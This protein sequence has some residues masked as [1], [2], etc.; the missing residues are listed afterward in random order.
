MKYQVEV[1]GSLMVSKVVLV[2]T[3]ISASDRSISTRQSWVKI[4][5]AWVCYGIYTWTLLAD[6]FDIS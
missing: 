4:V 6:R 3:G 5:S 1:S 2:G